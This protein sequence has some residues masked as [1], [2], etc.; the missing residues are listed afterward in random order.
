MHEIAEQVRQVRGAEIILERSLHE[1]LIVSDPPQ[2]VGD[3]GL[4][5]LL[6]NGRYTLREWKYVVDRLGC[7]AGSSSLETLTKANYASLIALQL[8]PCLRLT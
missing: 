4:C 1:E 3:R 5:L 8:W 2:P 6:E 7:D